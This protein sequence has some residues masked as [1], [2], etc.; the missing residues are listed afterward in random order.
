MHTDAHT[1]TNRHTRMKKREQIIKTAAA[2]GTCLS[3]GPLVGRVEVVA[4]RPRIGHGGVPLGGQDLAE[5][6]DGKGRAW[7]RRKMEKEEPSRGGEE[8]GKGRAWQRR[9]GRWKRKSLAEEGRK[10][11]REEEV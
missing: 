4:R 5:E 1:H 11:D 6:E 3:D 10:V 7:Q 2:G 8:D 9:R